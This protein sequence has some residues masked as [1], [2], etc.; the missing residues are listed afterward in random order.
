[1]VL[2]EGTDDWCLTAA[3]DACIIGR[4]EK[5]FAGGSPQGVIGADLLRALRRSDITL[6]NLETPICATPAPIPK[7]GPNFIASATIVPAMADAGFDVVSLANNHILDQ[8]D[9]GLNETIEHL[10][11]AGILHHGAASSHE[12]AAAGVF[13]DGGT[14]RVAFLNVAEGEF[15]QAQGTGSGAARLDPGPTCLRIA[16]T[17]AEADHLVLSC[18]A[19]NEYQPFPSPALQSIYRSFVDA[20]ADAVIGHHPHLPQGVE[21]HGKGVIIYSLGNFLSDY[22]GHTGKPCTRVGFLARLGFDGDGVREIRVIPF[23]KAEDASVDVPPEAG[24]GAFV[25][26]IRRVSAPLPDLQLLTP[27][28]EQECRMLYESTYRPLLARLCPAMS[29]GK[30]PDAEGGRIMFNLFRCDAHNEAMQTAFRLMH[31]GR[32]GDDAEARIEIEGA[33]A[34]LD[35]VLAAT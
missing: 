21:I 6:I 14:P 16:K 29:Q 30:T 22:T 35:D 20:G 4:I 34:L 23:T 31:E 9:Q 13:A 1:M 26:Y 12:K 27:L 5:A 32:F 17:A 7:T 2:R 18:H 11:R 19:G 33:L 24:T 28:W 25:K 10:D 3:G 8:G 15:A